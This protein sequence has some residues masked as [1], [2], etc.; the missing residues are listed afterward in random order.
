[1]I[2]LKLRTQERNTH[3]DKAL[4]TAV[5]LMDYADTINCKVHRNKKYVEQR[6]AQNQGFVHPRKF[7]AILK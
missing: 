2:E 6:V 1:M 5:E 4:K 3:Q 7:C